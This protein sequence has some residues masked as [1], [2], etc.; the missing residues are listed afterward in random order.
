MKFLWEVNSK[1]F[2]WFMKRNHE[3]SWSLLRDV[4]LSLSVHFIPKSLNFQSSTKPIWLDVWFWNFRVCIDTSRHSTC[5]KF[6]PKCALFNEHDW[7]TAW[8]TFWLISQRSFQLSVWKFLLTYYVHSPTY[9]A[10]FVRFD[11]KLIVWGHFKVRNFNI[12]SCYCKS[13]RKSIE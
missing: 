4:I 9:C 13:W 1:V 8:N 5:R 2:Y 3:R 12:E 6:S 11:A 10:S 7:P